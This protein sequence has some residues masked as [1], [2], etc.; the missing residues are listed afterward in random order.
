M[1]ATTRF[2]NMIRTAFGALAVLIAISS[3]APAVAAAGSPDE[4]IRRMSTEVLS[5]IKGDEKIRNGDFHRVSA[6]VDETIMPNVNFDRMTALAVGRGWR[7]ATPEQ[8]TK[9]VAEFRTLLL[10]TYSGALAQVRDQQVRMRPFRGSSDDD[11]VIVRSEIVSR[12]AEPIQLDYRMERAG[13][14][15]KIY[16]INVLGIWLVETY[17][18]Q[19]RQI[20]GSEGIDGLLKSLAEKNRQAAGQRG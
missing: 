17:R 12:G 8:R 6:F 16:D 5:R 9:L 4:L 7:D 20:Y 13:D 11:D 3:P 2:L 18:N 1:N 10:R 19:F 15:W 14:T